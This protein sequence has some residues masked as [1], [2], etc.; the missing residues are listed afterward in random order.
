MFLPFA[1]SVQRGGDV[2][3]S[4]ATLRST[5]KVELRLLSPVVGLFTA[6]PVVGV[7]TC[8]LLFGNVQVAIAMTIGANLIAIVSLIGAP[9]VSLRLVVIDAVLMAASVMVSSATMTTLWLHVPLL[10]LWCFLGGLLVGFGIP[11]GIVGTQA[12]IAFVVLGRFAEQPH[13]AVELGLAVLLGSVVEIGGLLLLRLPPSLRHQRQQLARGLDAVADQATRTSSQSVADVVQTLDRAEGELRAPSLYGRSDV[14]DLR[15][16]LDQV[17]RIRLQL[18]SLAGLRARVEQ[19]AAAPERATLETVLLS[20]HDVLTELADMVRQPANAPVL[21][22]LFSAF[23]VALDQFVS[24]ES[25]L[26]PEQQLLVRQCISNLDAL[27]GQLRAARGLV[28]RLGGGN[29]GQGVFDLPKR[30]A[31][32]LGGHAPS[33]LFEARPWSSPQVLRHALRLSVA[34]PVSLLLASWLSLPRPY[35][36]PFAVVTILKPDYGSLLRRGIGRVVGT[37]I[38][39]SLAAVLIELLHPNET[40]TVV[41]AAL[42]AWAA[43]TTWKANFAVGIGFVTA[44]MLIV[45]SISFRDSAGTAFDRAL[46]VVVGGAIALLSYLLWPSP[47]RAGVDVTLASLFQAIARYVESVGGFVT[48]AGPPREVVHDS[49]RATRLS[50]AAADAAVGAVTLEPKVSASVVVV[51]RG[52][53][54]AALRIIRACHALRLDAERG[55]RAVEHEALAGLFATLGAELSQVATNLRGQATPHGEVELREAFQAVSTELEQAGAP[56]SIALHLDELV[57]AV[58]TARFLLHPWQSPET[59][60]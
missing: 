15:A 21:D 57:N 44:L 30:R 26:P 60:W 47:A 5:L 55:N 6:L 49:A 42:V 56:R 24:L 39:A 18:T 16:L 28:D 12:V 35:W 8:G 10:I 53:L 54:A 4:L 22:R 41:L 3:S 34:V 7:F 45:L 37:L 32:T 38:G 13:R 11:Q 2:T 20:A 33:R 46:D 58:N 40:L 23:D 9:R 17:R 51:D 52:L 19:L 29:R 48:S 25:S 59:S 31:L 27:G 1:V 36:V 14:R 43:Y 50:W